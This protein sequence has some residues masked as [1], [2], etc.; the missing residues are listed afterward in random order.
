MVVIPIT[1]IKFFMFIFI[2]IKVFFNLTK[3]L[4]K[5]F[6]IMYADMRCLRS[7]YGWNDEERGV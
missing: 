7:K 2:K 3:I 5:I 4:K 6:H 1:I